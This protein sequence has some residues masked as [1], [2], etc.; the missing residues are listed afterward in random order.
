MMGCYMEYVYYIVIPIITSILGGLI[1]GLFTFLGVKLTLKDERRRF[2]EDKR[3]RVIEK[4]KVIIKNRP[5]LK[6]FSIIEACKQH[7][8]EYSIF[9]FPFYKPELINKND[10]IF[11]YPKGFDDEKFLHKYTLYFKNIGKTKLTRGLLYLDDKSGINI[12]DSVI[13]NARNCVL[14]EKLYFS[15]TLSFSLDLQPGEIFKLNIFYPKESSYIKDFL[16]DIYYEDEYGNY[17]VQYGIN[18]I[19]NDISAFNIA[20]RLEYST[21]LR[22][23]MNT[24][25]EYNR[26]FYSKDTKKSFNYIPKEFSKYLEKEKNKWHKIYNEIE[27]F[28]YEC[29]DGK[30]S[31]KDTYPSF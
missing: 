4:N 30:V 11:N 13:L 6:S 28:K 22:Q 25:F 17:W 2:E 15:N 27:K 5:I 7:I 19:D 3:L 24:F 12:Y 9:L 29:K 10:I 18:I 26:M 14:Y 31:L 21:Y 16:F 1:G 23:E 8:P 20:S